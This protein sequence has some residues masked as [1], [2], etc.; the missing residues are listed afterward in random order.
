[1]KKVAV[2]LAYVST[3]Y[4]VFQ[5]NR[6]VRSVLTQLELALNQA[7]F[8]SADK[9]G[10]PAKYSGRDGVGCA[11]GASHEL[12]NETLVTTIAGL[13]QQHQFGSH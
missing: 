10:C 6:G 5:I 13:G 2:L 11:C 3:H 4:V 7:G 8:I 1:M 12:Q 9:I